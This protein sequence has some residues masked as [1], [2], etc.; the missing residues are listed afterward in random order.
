MLIEYTYHLLVSVF[1]K[2]SC[3]TN[4]ENVTAYCNQHNHLKI[5]IASLK[6]SVVRIRYGF[7]KIVITYVNI[8]II[9]G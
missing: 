8:Q 7:H 3:L 6:K 2:G 9:V 5:I 4:R 1:G